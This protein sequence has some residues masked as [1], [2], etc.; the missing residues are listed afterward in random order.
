[1]G[2]W[3]CSLLTDK[4]TATMQIAKRLYSL[5]QQQNDARIMLGAS[6]ALAAT[7][8]WLGNFESTRQYAT[9]AVRI[10][11]SGG[12]QSHPKDIDVVVVSCFCYKALSEWHLREL[13]S[14]KT[15][16]EEAIV[17]A[18]ELNN[19]AALG[20]ALYFAVHLAH[21]EGNP[22]EVERLA[23]DLIELSARQGLINWLPG[24][25]VLRGWAQSASGH[26]AE[27]IACIEDGIRDYRATPG[28]L[29]YFLSLKAEA[30]YLAD[31]TVE[32][33]ETIKEAQVAAERSEARFWC[34]ELHR[35]R[36]VFLTALGAD[37]THIE[38]SFCEAIRIAKEQKSLSL[39]KRAEATYA[40]YGRQKANASGGRGIRLPLW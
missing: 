5:A 29:P 1:M 18:R 12:V 17:L 26:T 6:N 21:F 37:E 36:G 22:A 24:G 20:L 11:R 39:E 7:H 31:R 23:S 38:A 3:V 10:W 28:R 14:Y 34:A 9:P 32:A 30:L 35:L 40:E 15:T 25:V 8:Y 13:D 4:L 19:M 33:L 16:M 27:S 2:Q